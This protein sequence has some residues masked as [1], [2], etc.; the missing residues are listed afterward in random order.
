MTTP[1][2][3]Q[4]PQTPSTSPDS[5]AAEDENV[6]PQQAFPPAS[7]EPPR[8]SRLRAA[9]TALVLVAAIVA[10]L[11]VAG[12]VMR[13]APTTAEVGSCV[14]NAGTDAKPD[15]SVVD[16]GAANAEFKVL[17]VVRTADE[18]QCDTVDGVE[19]SY[20]EERSSSMFVLC[21]GR[22]R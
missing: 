12:Y 14:H 4:T 2:T 16:C 21:L 1:S 8:R 6:T 11:F 5:Q 7:T 15:V 20:S 17:K 18:S 19:A 22:N 13:D 10:A 3:P 9:L